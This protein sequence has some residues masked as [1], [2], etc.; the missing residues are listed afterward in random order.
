MDYDREKVDE[1]VLALL[2]LTMFKDKHCVRA[3]KSPRLGRYGPAT[4]EGV[5]LRSEE[6]SEV[7]GDDQRGRAAGAEAVRAALWRHCLSRVSEMPVLP[8]CLKGMLKGLSSTILNQEEKNG[9][10]I[11]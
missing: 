10:D 1:M 2:A 6:P 3:W 7:G 5:H 4:R 8:I 11:L 9:T